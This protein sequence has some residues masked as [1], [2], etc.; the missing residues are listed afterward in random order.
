MLLKM[1]KNNLTLAPVCMLGLLLHCG[2]CP[3]PSLVEKDIITN[4]S[5]IYKKHK[6]HFTFGLLC[7]AIDIVNKY[8]F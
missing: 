3:H 2:L 7:D 8:N 6:K 1:S 4:V 5:Y